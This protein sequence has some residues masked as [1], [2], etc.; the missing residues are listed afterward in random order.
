MTEAIWNEMKD[1]NW[2]LK[3]IKD[4]YEARNNPKLIYKLRE[5][6]LQ[7]VNITEK[8]L[9]DSAKTMLENENNP[10]WHEIIVPCRDKENIKRICVFYNDER[11]SSEEFASNRRKYTNAIFPSKT[12]R[13]LNE[14]KMYISLLEDSAVESA[15][16]V[17][18]YAKKTLL[19]EFES[20]KN[21]MKDI[22]VQFLNEFEA[23]I[24]YP[25]GDN[26]KM[27]YS[28]ERVLRFYKRGI[29]ADILEDGCKIILPESDKKSDLK[30]LHNLWEDTHHY[31]HLLFLY[32]SY[33]SV[34]EKLLRQITV[35]CFRY[36]IDSLVMHKDTFLRF[37]NITQDYVDGKITKEEMFSNA[38]LT[39][40][41][42]MGVSFHT[43][44]MRNS[45]HFI[46]YD[47][48]KKA[49]LGALNQLF[50]TIAS[51]FMN[52]EDFIKYNTK[53]VEIIRGYLD[54]PFLGEGVV[55]ID[56]DLLKFL[57]DEETIAMVRYGSMYLEVA[58]NT[59]FNSRI[60]KKIKK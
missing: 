8:L 41:L 43:C 32:L 10:K 11:M 18:N 37:V 39:P 46:R 4:N 25:F 7:V 36:Y 42:F 58:N 6:S 3:F 26:V 49:T 28:V 15:F 21:L 35:D 40:R 59:S 54:N 2:R 19:I 38:D 30:S 12:F 9:D 48:I 55:T 31:N 47:D 17:Y 1:I 50:F 53:F 24:I 33:C 14:K 44:C 51:G 45:C 52:Y 60:P 20:D 34:N 16:K 27:N 23:N 56:L 22:D 5:F 29:T 13:D 57:F